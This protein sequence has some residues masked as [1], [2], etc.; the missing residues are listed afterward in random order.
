MPAALVTRPAVTQ[1]SPFLP[2]QWSQGLPVF[3]VPIHE[4]MVR[5]HL[6]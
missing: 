2:Q 6:K 4:G 5:K 1:N 3:T